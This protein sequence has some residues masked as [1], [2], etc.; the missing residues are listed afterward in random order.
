MGADAMQRGSVHIRFFHADDPRLQFKRGPST[1]FFD[2]DDPRFELCGFVVRVAPV[3]SSGCAFFVRVTP[4]W[5]ARRVSGAMRSS[6]G[7]ANVSNT[8]TTRSQAYGRNHT[9]S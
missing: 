7:V 5:T 8:A 6:S 3:W 1:S 2:A 9:R 4:V